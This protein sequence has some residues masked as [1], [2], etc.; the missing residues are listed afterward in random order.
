MGR[1]GSSGSVGRLRSGAEGSPANYSSY[2]LSILIQTL[3][4][5]WV[6]DLDF[7]R[8]GDVSMYTMRHLDDG[9]GEVYLC[10]K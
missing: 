2:R 7:F 8:F 5:R 9:T 3:G 4:A 10:P 6:S 1:T